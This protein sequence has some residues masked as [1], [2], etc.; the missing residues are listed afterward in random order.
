[1]RSA[2]L[3]GVADATVSTISKLPLAWVGAVVTTGRAVTGESATGSIGATDA[4]LEATG[5]L[6]A[7]ESAVSAGCVA[8]A[9]SVFRAAKSDTMATIRAARDRS[10]FDMV[11]GFRPR[12]PRSFSRAGD[13]DGRINARPPRRK[14]LSPR[15]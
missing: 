11:V 13:W 7:A 10:T 6:D 15:A 2:T 9:A 14:L 3:P 12:A 1:M 4:E 5:A 8:Q